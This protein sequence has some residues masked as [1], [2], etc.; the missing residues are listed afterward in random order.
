MA[1]FSDAVGKHRAACS[2]QRQP[3]WQW[4]SSPSV[5]WWCEYHGSSQPVH[6]GVVESRNARSVGRVGKQR[7]TFDTTINN[8]ILFSSH[9]ASSISFYRQRIS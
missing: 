5:G 7:I 6:K 3:P 4:R 8:D 9:D 1:V 2:G